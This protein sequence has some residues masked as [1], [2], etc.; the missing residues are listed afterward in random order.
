M[1]T[2]A[3]GEMLVGSERG[4]V[5]VAICRPSI[6]ESAMEEPLSGWMEVTGDGL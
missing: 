5:P 1:F 3:M 4:A 2:K 6:V